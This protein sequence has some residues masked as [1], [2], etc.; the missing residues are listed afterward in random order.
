MLSCQKGHFSLPDEI[1]YLN[2]AYLSPLMKSVEEAGITGLRKKRNP[3][4]ISPDD[5]FKESEEL[6]KIFSHLINNPDPERIAL[7]PSV[8]YG[9]ANVAKNVPF[10]SGDHILVAGY[11]FPS[12]YYPW[13]QL[14]IEAGVELK[15][16]NPPEKL[17]SRGLKWNEQIM[18]AI[19]AKTRLVALPQVHW[20]DG[21]KFNLKA[22]R[23]KLDQ[24]EGYLVIDGTQSVGAHPFDVQE[25]KPD[26]LICAGYKWL[27]GPYAMGVGYYGKRFDN[28]TPIEH[29]WIN[30]KDS[31]DF[32]NLVN[33]QMDYQPGALR[34]EVGEHSNFILVPMLLE[35]V[36]KIHS[37]G[38]ENI[39]KYCRSIVKDTIGE[40][41]SAGFF[42]EDEEFRSN[43]LFG[44][45]LP[46]GIKPAVVKQALE[47]EK[48]Y[49]STRGTSVRVSPNIY[50]TREDM[51]ALAGVLQRLI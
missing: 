11:Q 47:D 13:K 32:T 37:F 9:M 29:N 26:A 41:Q 35:A 44:I 3:T 5:F 34:Y 2:C 23:E 43:H 25:I 33:Y 18:N 27:M 20:A 48:I 50:N 31:Q 38:V 17:E 46:E 8:S 45:Y 21:T 42:I 19:N 24:H 4:T 36:R 6:R 16:I 49:V 28:G 15:T 14:A 39:Q 12:N 40:L 7:I 10:S 22:I 30:R 51:D 1:H